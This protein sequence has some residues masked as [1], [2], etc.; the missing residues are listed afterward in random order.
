MLLPGIVERCALANPVCSK[1]G[2]VGLKRNQST[3]SE[4]VVASAVGGVYSLP[5]DLPME[6]AVSVSVNPYT[7][8]STF[9]TARA[10]GANAIVHTAAAS[11]LGQMMVKLA[12]TEGTEVINV[13]RRAEQVE[14]LEKIGAAH[15]VVTGGTTPGKKS[16]RPK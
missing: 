9:D 1:V 8:L 14:L 15:I 12:P 16:L 2:F 10:E 11:E 7:A 3:Y 4:Y 5:G 6:D 13:A